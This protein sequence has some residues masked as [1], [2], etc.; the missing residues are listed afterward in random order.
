MIKKLFYLFFF[1]CSIFILA[2]SGLRLL[3]SF[4][5]PSLAGLRNPYNFTERNAQDDFW[6]L[7][8][9]WN[10]S[11][12]R[13][14]QRV[15]PVLGWSQDLITKENPLGFEQ[16]TLD[17]IPKNGKQDFLFYGDSFVKGLA[18][19]EYFMARYMN[20]LMPEVDVVDL[21]VGGYGSDQM[22]LLFQRTWMSFE[23]PVV[24]VGMLLEDVDRAV[25]QIFSNPKPRFEISSEGTLDLKGVPVPSDP[26]VFF[27]THPPEIKSY[28][29]G[30]FLMK[31]R[32]VPQ[33]RDLKKRINSKIMEEFKRVCGQEGMP[34]IYV[35]FYGQEQL[36]TLD[37]RET[38]L[39]NE[40]E[41]NGIPYFDSK[42]ALIAYA[43]SHGLDYSE[44]YTKKP[45]DGHMV[46]LGNKVI[47]EALVD[48]LTAKGYYHSQN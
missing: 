26:A 7:Y 29:A 4:N 17:L 42:P 9:L 8:A 21:S 12:T 6:K 13:T 20:R 32:K 2:E 14:P 40:L 22:L 48:Y 27:K 34:L 33:K 43:Q 25:L 16:R 23:K 10:G 39:K 36:R 47:S 18:S 35:L 45:G 24:I 46:D 41:K 3:L 38:F 37:W 5:T 44:F 28:L 19:E 31:F 30:Y 11:L 15:H 1:F